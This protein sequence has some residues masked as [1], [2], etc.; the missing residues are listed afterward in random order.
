MLLLE[1]SRF[2]SQWEKQRRNLQKNVPRP[3]VFGAIN[4]LL[5]FVLFP[6]INNFHL[7]YR[8]RLS[9]ENFFV[10]KFNFLV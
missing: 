9:R 4:K 3:N 5:G 10:G 7:I 8:L 1:F 2:S 6:F